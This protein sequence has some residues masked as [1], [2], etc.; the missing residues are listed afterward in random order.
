MQM[1]LKLNYKE[2]EEY[3]F[4]HDWEKDKEWKH[5]LSM[6][7]PEWSPGKLYRMKRRWYSIHF[8]R[9]FSA[10]IGKTFVQEQK[11]ESQAPDGA[12]QLNARSDLVPRS[13]YV[14][15]RLTISK[16]IPELKALQFFTW[17]FSFL[18]IFCPKNV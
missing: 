10:T 9:K 3:F 7:Y 15:Q 16:P 8:D 5:H 6:V 14:R 13:F 18:L 17:I 12:I 11:E 1:N 2:Q 4:K